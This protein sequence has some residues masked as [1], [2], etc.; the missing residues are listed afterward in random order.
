MG[1]VHHYRTLSIEELT[2]VLSTAFAHLGLASPNAT[3]AI[4][5]IVRTAAGNCRLV[6]RLHAA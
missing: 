5:A 2:T 6:N 1:F 4:T 3:E